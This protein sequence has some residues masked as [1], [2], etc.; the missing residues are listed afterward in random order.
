[1]N[2]TSDVKNPDIRKDTDSL[3]KVAALARAFQHRAA[4]A[5]ADIE[6]TLV[7]GAQR[8]H[9]LNVFVL[10]HHKSGF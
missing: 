9:S 6:A 5:T 7:Q 4:S 1:M 8:A 2:A 10:P 3:G